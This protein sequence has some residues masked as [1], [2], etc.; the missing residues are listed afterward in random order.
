MSLEE[1]SKRRG[2][3]RLFLKHVLL[4]ALCV[5]S[6]CIVFC[7]VFPYVYSCLFYICVEVYGP[8]TP[9][10]NPV[11]VNKYRI[12]RLIIEANTNICLFRTK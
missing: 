12:L 9:G 6:F 11:A 2:A 5:L 8:L 7:S 3:G 4:S 1:Y 10:G